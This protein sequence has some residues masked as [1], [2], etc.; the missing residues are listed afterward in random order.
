MKNKQNNKN[1]YINKTKQLSSMMIA[2]LL[3]ITTF[4]ALLSNATMPEEPRGCS[5]IFNIPD[6]TNIMYA[7]EEPTDWSTMFKLEIDG[8]TGEYDMH[9]GIYPGWCVDYG[10]A[11]PQ[12]YDNPHN[13]NLE[14]SYFPSESLEDEDW[15]KINYIL[16]HKQGDRY[17]VQRAIWY[18]VNFGSW[19]WNYTG[20]MEKPVNQAVYDMIDDANENS[21]D[22]CPECGDIVAIINNPVIEHE[23]QITI[24]EMPY[25]CEDDADNDG[26]PDDGDNCPETY[27]PDQADSDFDGIGD[28]CDDSSGDDDDDDDDQGDCDDNDGDNQCPDC[29]DNN[30]DSW[31]VDYFYYDADGDGYYKDG[32]NRRDDGMMAICYGDEIP[33]GYTT[34]SYGEDCDDT[35]PNITDECF[36]DDDDDSTGDDDD[37]DST[38]DDDDDDSTGDDDDDDSR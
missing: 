2:M 32:P 25:P 14:S 17:D 37:D 23:F 15:H 10:T 7:W 20:Y 4:A 33:E 12:G 36:D 21:D 31:R 19:E 24:N 1:N 22:W 38:G 8:I 18:F 9:N 26:I 29:N 16:N 35:D 13:V 27:N 5:P 34:F 30:P 11:I 28:A 6:N 3:I